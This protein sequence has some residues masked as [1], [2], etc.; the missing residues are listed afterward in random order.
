[1]RALIRD[2]PIGQAIRFFNPR[3]LPYP[4][5]RDD[6]ELPPAYVQMHGRKHTPRTSTSASSE[7]PSDEDVPVEEV[8]PETE[9]EA[10]EKE[11]LADDSE[12]T[13][14]DLEKIR[15]AGTTYTARSQMSRVGT[16]EALSRAHTRAD[17]EQQFSLAT[18]EK[19]P[20]RPIEPEVRDDGTILVDWYATDDAENPQNWSFGKKLVVLTQILIYTMAVYMGSAIYSP[21]IPG[22]MEQFGV[23]LQLAS[24][25]LSMYV[26]AYGIGP[27]LFSP[28]SEIPVIGRNPPYIISYAIF[29][30]LLVP[31][32]LV[33]SFPG[34]IVLRFL[35]GF[36][37][38]PCLA[39]GG[40]TLQDLYSIIKL[41]YVLSLWAFAATCGPALGPIISGFSVAAKNWHW[42]QWEMLWMNGPVFLSLFVFLPETSSN[43]ILLR[44]AARLR[45]L[46]G[47]ARL[48]SQSEIDQSNLTPREIAIEALWRPFQLVLLDPSIAFTAVYTALIYGIFY[49]FFE[50][51]PLVYEA[52]YHFNLGE[53]GL[54]FLSVTAG[55]I[56]AIAAYWSY[57]FRIVEPEIRRNGLGA[58]ERRLIPALIVTWFVPA[59]LF[60]FG[61]T[62]NA[63][64]HWIVSCVGIAITT[65]GIFL[66]IQCIFLYL[67]LVYPQYAASLFAGN[68]FMRSALATGAIHFSSPMFRNLG[69]GKGI[70]LL[71]GLT[72]GCSAGV[73]VLFFFGAKLRARSRFAAQ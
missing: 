56:I 41:P 1:M 45:A 10:E 53:M 60:L 49:S 38:S 58:P 5:E 30:V 70:S 66:I 42:S 57:I 40:A 48:K 47:D 9:K 71:A 51:F 35:Q 18:I 44:R 15:T 54:T 43:T 22:V 39:T 11:S 37:G 17:L 16:R 24:M 59:G 50:A 62:S 69:I 28:L 3:L 23:N 73:Y 8:C 65:I 20:S 13:S 2:A 6:F 68:D 4:E 19:G 14:D 27:L 67:P 31:S 46:T 61:W 32:S 21:S 26:L 64:I 36:F 72:V 63:D 34:L 7:P 25:G 29:V 52:L 33:N 12:S 55:V